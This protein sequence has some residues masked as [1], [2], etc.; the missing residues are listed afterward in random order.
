[1]N[2]LDTKVRVQLRNSMLHER[3]QERST[4]FK[5]NWSTIKEGSR[6]EVH[7]PSYSMD[8]F[9][10]LT[11]SHFRHREA[12]GLTR[13]FALRDPSLEMIYV[14][15]LEANSEV[16]NYY[17]KVLEV[18][19]VVNAQSRVH[20]VFPENSNKFVYSFSVSQLLYYS[21]I[22]LKQI[23]SLISGKIAYIVPLMVGKEDF[24]IADYLNVCIFSPPFDLVQDLCRKSVS[25]QLFIDLEYNMLK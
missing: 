3:Q 25:K 18:A 8:K 2:Y 12:L 6:V 9:Q 4:Y 21:P 5:L 16:I 20:F 10:R 19:G 17:W 13:L 23:K 7:L 22:A 1:M 15:P 14:L 11:M 24:L